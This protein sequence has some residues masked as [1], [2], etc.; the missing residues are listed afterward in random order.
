MSDPISR[1]SFGSMTAGA[2]VASGA[3]GVS[4]LE[5]AEDQPKHGAGPTGAGPIEAP[6]ERD[7]AP[8]SFRP[9]WKKPQINRVLAQEFMSATK[10]APFSPCTASSRTS[11]SLPA[12][13][14]KPSSR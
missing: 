14:N 11:A 10:G 13:S 7:Y 12:R 9:S 5:A 6:F 3:A 8:P 2:V 1:R 4:G